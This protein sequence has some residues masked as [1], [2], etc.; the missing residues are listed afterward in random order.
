M[1]RDD[2]CTTR[3]MGSNVPMNPNRQH[4]ATTMSGKEMSKR[5][6]KFSGNDLATDSRRAVADVTVAVFKLMLER[7]PEFETKGIHR[8]V[9][10]RREISR[11][12]SR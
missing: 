1:A 2:N 9:Q 7:L 4:P 12:T 10:L 6:A 3:G 5:D 11:R 8:K